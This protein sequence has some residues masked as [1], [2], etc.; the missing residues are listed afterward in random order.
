MPE[1]VRR[2]TRCR[3]EARARSRYLAERIG[4]ALGD[5]RAGTGR[6]QAQVAAEVGISQPHYSRIE[7]GLGGRVPFEV[8]AACAL[9]CDTQLAAFLEALP[10]A[11]LPRD[12]EHLR[13]QQA[14]IRLA[15]QGG[16]RA[17][18]ERPIDPDA[19][20]SRSI[21]VFLDR[22]VR[23]ELAV[24]EIVDLILD[25][26]ATMRGHT[27]KINA[28]RREAPDGWSVAGLLVVRGT[29]RNRALVRSHADVF[30]ARYPA[31]SRQWLAALSDT[32]AAMPSM[33]GLAWTAAKTAELHAARL[34]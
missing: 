21:D 30:L 32:R 16:W 17:M 29:H 13:R 26:G 28:I 14:V 3:M 22:S 8:L 11:S 27:D 5:A 25:A 34:H 19:A 15:A 12:L 1:R 10:G 9:A 24:V 7:R 6:T 23:R 31:R 2:A 33:D 20:R 18:P 4:R